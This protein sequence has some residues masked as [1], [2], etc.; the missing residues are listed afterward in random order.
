MVPPG[1][2]GMLS[3]PRKSS[4]RASVIPSGQQPYFEASHVQI[5]LAFGAGVLPSL[6]QPKSVCSQLH[7]E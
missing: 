7:P 2:S 1:L 3:H 4:S 6:Q 5:R